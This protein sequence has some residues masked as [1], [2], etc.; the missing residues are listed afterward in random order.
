[1]GRRKAVKGA[2]K[3]PPQHA[4]FLT[5]RWLWCDSDGGGSAWDTPLVR[6]TQARGCAVLGRSST[7]FVGNIPYDAQEEELRN[8]FSRAGS[9][10]SFRLVF[11]KDTKQPKG[12][13]FCDYSDADTALSAIRNL[14]DVEFNG[15]RLRIDLADNALRSREAA[16]K[17]LLPLP[18]QEQPHQARPPALPPPVPAQLALPIP[19]GMA[20]VWPQTNITW[21]P[22]NPS[23]NIHPGNALFFPETGAVEVSVHTEIAQTVSAMP[24]AQLQLCLGAMQKLAVE[25]PES[26]RALLHEHPQLCYALL[27][28]QLL[29]GLALEPVM[30]PSWEEM[31]RMRVPP[32]PTPNVM[33]MPT[34]VSGLPGA[35][36]RPPTGLSAVPTGVLS[37]HG[38]SRPPGPLAAGKPMSTPPAHMVALPGP[39]VSSGGGVGST[40]A[41]A[42]VPMG[43]QLRPMAA[44]RVPNPPELGPRPGSMSTPGQDPW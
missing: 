11:D 16:E 10:E 30:P 43:A 1:M 14:N 41:A 44:P 32:R 38:V 12:Y 39:H 17:T 7:V 5:N 29:L 18:A 25:A 15:R 20:P 9:V 37:L 28:I 24:Q 13:G 23:A 6:M 21:P 31:Q 2:L 36:L 42:G 33:L 19:P 26:A 27:H 4:V 3:D 35:S 8:I 22:P 34:N 40:P